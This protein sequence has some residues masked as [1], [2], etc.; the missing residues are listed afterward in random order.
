MLSNGLT[1]RQR[2]CREQNLDFFEIADELGEEQSY[3]ADR[4]VIFS[5]GQPGSPIAGE[6]STDGQPDE[7]PAE[8]PQN[9]E[10]IDE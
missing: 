3:L 9:A 10:S 1:S 2:L 8:Q 4:G 7:E 6:E 5:I